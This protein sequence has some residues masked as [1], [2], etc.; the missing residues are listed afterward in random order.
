[1]AAQRDNGGED[2]TKRQ[3]H[4]LFNTG[5]L[6]SNNALIHWWTNDRLDATL[7][8]RT[9]LNQLGTTVGIKENMEIVQ[10]MSGNIVTEVGKGLGFA[11]QNAN[12]AG[13][14]QLG[15]SGN[16]NETK[17]YTQYQGGFARDRTKPAEFLAPLTAF[18]T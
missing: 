14:A 17:L 15:S 16:S 4:I 12:K 18:F 6:L 8:R 7:G 1:M 13:P 2:P 10:N 9:N 5:S 11:M 3:S